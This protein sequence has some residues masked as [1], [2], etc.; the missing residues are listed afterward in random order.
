MEGSA[1]GA[2]CDKVS[3]RQTASRNEG[4]HDSACQREAIH[5]VLCEHMGVFGKHS[6]PYFTFAFVKGVWLMQLIQ[7]S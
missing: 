5:P 1:C 3:G 2:V 6:G 4:T 7:G